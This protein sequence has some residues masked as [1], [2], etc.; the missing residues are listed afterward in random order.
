M[1]GPGVG[2]EDLIERRLGNDLVLVHRPADGFRNLREVDATVHECFNS[3]FIRGVKD[4]GKSAADLAGFA[5][6]FER[7]ETFGIRFFEGKAAEFGEICLD[8]STGSAIRI[9]ERVL[10]GQAHVRRGKLCEHGAIDEFNH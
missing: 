6:E 7:G 9:G 2:F 1:A 5:G 10:D 3:N 8:A 4:C